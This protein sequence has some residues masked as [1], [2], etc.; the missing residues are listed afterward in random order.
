MDTIPVALR[1]AA[2]NRQNSVM[3]FDR[4]DVDRFFVTFHQLKRSTL[5]A[6]RPISNSQIWACAFLFEDDKCDST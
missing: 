4:G 1:A 6:E 5:T 2:A 3:I